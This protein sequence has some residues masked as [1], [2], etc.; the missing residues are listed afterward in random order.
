MPAVAMLAAAIVPAKLMVL[1]VGGATQ[2]FTRLCY[3][4]AIIPLAD[5]LGPAGAMI[6]AAAAGGKPFTKPCQAQK[7]LKNLFLSLD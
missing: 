5:A 3:A 7:T 6:A 2:T 1:V 4:C